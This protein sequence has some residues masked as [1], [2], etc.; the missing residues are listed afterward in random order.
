[1]RKNKLII[2]GS[3]SNSL[4]EPFTAV[5]KLCISIS[6][7]IIK[8]KNDF[9]VNILSIKRNAGL[10][11]LLFTINITEYK[12]K[13]ITVKLLSVLQLFN[14]ARKSD[15]AL[16]LTSHY[17]CLILVLAKLINNKLKIIFYT[18]GIQ[19]QER[20]M[21]KGEEHRPS[22]F[23]VMIEK[24]VFDFGSVII[25]PSTLAKD[26]IISKYPYLQNKI[27]VIPLVVDDGF[28]NNGQKKFS[29]TNNTIVTVATYYNK[30]ELDF[31]IRMLKYIDF[32]LEI[33][34]VG[35]GH[36]NYEK[37]LLKII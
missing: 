36:L 18:G 30:K 32:P 4:N 3:F 35:K 19:F 2:V 37:K 21:G 22:F 27:S 1:M 34:I 25:L 8:T 11:S 13:N 17:H 29:L 7:E 31:T 33:K 26:N 14:I 28:I 10:L 20:I 6:S 23:K 12:I 24:V 9:D 15:F 16:C 5:R